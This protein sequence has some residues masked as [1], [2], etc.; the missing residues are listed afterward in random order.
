MWLIGAEQAVFT[1]Q[2]RPQA[3]QLPKRRIFLQFIG[4]N[5]VDWQPGFPWLCAT[6]G[7]VEK[8]RLFGQTVE[9][10]PFVFQDADTLGLLVS[11]H[12]PV[13]VVALEAEEFVELFLRVPVFQLR[14][15][16]EHDAGSNLP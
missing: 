2:P 10:V 9:V 6:L 5:V 14:A 15:I 13:L 12:D 7:V 4:R 16:H 8:L 11:E 1:E 3:V